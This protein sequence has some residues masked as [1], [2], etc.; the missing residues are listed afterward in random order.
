MYAGILVGYFGRQD[1]ARKAFK[2]LH[3]NGFHLA[4]YASRGAAGDLHVRDPLGW[5]LRSGTVLAFFLVGALASAVTTGFHWT[6]MGPWTAPPIPFLLWGGI[7][8][9]LYAQWKRR[10]APGISPAVI[11]E[12]ARWLVSGESVLILH[13][14][15]ERMHVPVAL[16]SKFGEFPP[17]VFIHYPDRP[18][19]P[20]EDGGTGKP[21]TGVQLQELARR[22]SSTHRLARGALH[23][24]ILLRRIERDRGWLHRCMSRS[25]GGE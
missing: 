11:G 13:V 12:Y 4:A 6:G 17:A 3:R 9:L 16:L 18:G 10:S 1:E 23:N 7:A 24:P 5:R 21:M 8:A 14:P 15:L 19:T 22:L 20:G 2:Q 25:C